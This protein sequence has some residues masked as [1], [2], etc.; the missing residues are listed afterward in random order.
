MFNFCQSYRLCVGLSLAEVRAVLTDWTDHPICA[1]GGRLNVPFC[2]LWDFT[3]PAGST[4]FPIRLTFVDDRL[5][6]WG[7]RTNAR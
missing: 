7:E 3:P 4:D 1:T 6:L 5:M 2:A